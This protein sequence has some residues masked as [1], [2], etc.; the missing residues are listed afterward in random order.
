MGEYSDT[1]S[2]LARDAEVTAPTVTLYANLGLLD[3]IRSSNGTRLFRPGQAQRVR[4]IYAERTA[5]RGR[6]TA[7]RAA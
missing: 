3:Y 6:R 1:N 2:K 4:E 5:N 7:S